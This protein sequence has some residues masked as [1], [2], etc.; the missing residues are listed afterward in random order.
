MAENKNT[1]PKILAVDDN[2]ANLIALEALFSSVDVELICVESGQEALQ[3][4]LNHDFALVLLD[5]HMPEM[6][7]FE[8]AR[9][10]SGFDRT[11]DIPIILIT[12]D[13]EDKESLIKGYESGAVDYIE[14]PINE[15]ILLAKVKMMLR[16]WSNSKALSFALETQKQLATRDA[17]TNLGNRRYLNER[18]M[19]ELPQH[20]SKG[21]VLSYL[22]IDLDRF[23]LV[24]DTLGHDIGDL[25]LIEVAHALTEGRDERDIV[26][27]VG[28]DE[29]IIVLCNTTEHQVATICENL[30]DRLSEV[31]MIK[32]N[33]VEIG[34]SIGIVMYPQDAETRER[35]EKNADTSLYLAKETG[36]G[37]YWFYDV[38]TN[39]KEE[40][41]QN[42]IDALKKGI[43]NDEFY[44]LYQP[45]VDVKTNKIVG[46]EA[47]M[48][49]QS[50]EFGFVGPDEF[51]PLLEEV[52]LISKVTLLM[53]EKSL[54]YFRQ[55]LDLD[56]N[57]EMS[58]NFS[59]LQIHDPGLATTLLEFLEA[60]NVPPMS[61]EV[62]ITE[63]LFLN[64]H[65]DV[66]VCLNQLRSSGCKIS[67]DDFGT[68]F[69]S[70]SYLKKLPI[71]T[72]K[73]D[74]AFIKDMLIDEDDKNLTR[75]IVG[76]AKV[77]SLNLV[78]EGV[79]EEAHR[80]LLLD[81]ECQYYQGYL[82]SKPVL[83]EEIIAMLT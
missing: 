21:E 83:P 82:F 61:F 63:G 52:R 80:Q 60:Y 48:R 75:A 11:K 13:A 25:L 49:W 32:G 45:R 81:M 46:F 33:E 65:E 2:P 68:G 56:P 79:E 59:P 9:Y 58:F 55:C 27:R 78:A 51:I 39:K 67:M 22:A 8:V 47:L 1:E 10:L 16:L 7:G 50:D 30:I 66:I 18:L 62:E 31:F 38:Y 15:M 17:L 34:A 54:S 42:I 23:K 69:S 44:M 4:V 3:L 19:I 74:R 73:I 5:V 24:N 20:V 6:D 43:E 37:R 64:D 14:K 35:L 41:R 71:D 70:L 72:L 77:F 12:A 28:G 36:R 29:F 57:L 76:I 26:C 40:R 53:F